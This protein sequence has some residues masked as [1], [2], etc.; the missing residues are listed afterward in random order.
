MAWPG[1]SGLPPTPNFG[2]S[3]SREGRAPS[4][5]CRG[6]W[7]KGRQAEAVPPVRV[8]TAGY[9]TAGEVSVAAH[10]ACVQQQVRCMDRY[11]ARADKPTP[12]YPWQALNPY[13]GSCSTASTSARKYLEFKY[14]TSAV[15]LQRSAACKSYFII[16]GNCY[17][18]YECVLTCNFSPCR[19]PWE[20]LY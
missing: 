13:G 19:H 15:K 4:A 17:K 14:K 2:F 6:F 5:V 20:V 7:E 16:Y 3:I 18:Y 1:D 12:S 11:G 9:G 8:R 10:A